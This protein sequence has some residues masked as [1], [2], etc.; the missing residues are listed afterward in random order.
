MA[1]V[2]GLTGGIGSGKSTVLAMLS[3]RGAIVIDADA[4]VH[5]EQRAGK[6]VFN[7][8]VE[9]F[10]PGIVGADGELDRP[11]VASIVFNDAE[12]L[13]RLNSIVHPAVGKEVMRLLGSAGETDVVVIDIPLLTENTRAERGLREVIVVDVPTDTQVARAVARGGQSEEDVRARI[14]SQ[15][16]RDDRL[17]LADHVIDNSGGMEA[18]EAQVDLL[19]KELVDAAGAGS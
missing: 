10:G 8:M 1:Y 6:P 5:D 2:V 3:A 17:A 19:W 14:A 9:A 18:L 7:E 13:K 11:K 12:Q 4:I 16:S 15:A